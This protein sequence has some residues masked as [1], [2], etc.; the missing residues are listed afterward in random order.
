MGNLSGKV[1]IVTGATRMRGLGKAVAEKRAAMGASV[2]VTGPDGEMAGA[3]EVAS[4]LGT[5][6]AEVS[7]L[8]ADVTRPDR[9][10]AAIATV[11]ERH[12]GWT[13]W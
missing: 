1:A 4:A 3:E 2:V 13:S 8:A 7:A 12:G 9:V 10:D 11:V 5:E 6:G